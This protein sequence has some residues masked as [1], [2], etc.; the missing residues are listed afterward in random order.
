MKVYGSK[1]VQLVAFVTI[2]FIMVMGFASALDESVASMNS[3]KQYSTVTI[4]Q[5]CKNSTYANITRI[6]SP[7]RIILNGQYSMSK[8]GNDYSYSYSNFTEIGDYYVYGICDED[9][10]YTTWAF[11]IPITSSGQQSQIALIFLFCIICIGL[12]VFGMYIQN[13]WVTI[14]GGLTTVLLGLFFLLNGIDTF[15]SSI[16]ESISIVLLF[17]GAFFSLVPAIE[18]IQREL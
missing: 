9:N 3:Q 4:V 7:T 17:V 6:V 14:I 16:T 11:T 18:L 10:T 13:E 2:A 12:I 1:K 5:N 15:R 8:T